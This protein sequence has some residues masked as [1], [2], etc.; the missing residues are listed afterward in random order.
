M[1][2]IINYNLISSSRLIFF[3]FPDDS[4]KFIRSDF[5]GGIGV[6]TALY[7]RVPSSKKT[8]P[9]IAQYFGQIPFSPE[10]PTGPG[11]PIGPA[12]PSSPGIP[13]TP[14]SPLGPEGP[15]GP[16]GPSKPGGPGGPGGPEFFI[17]F[18]YS[19]KKV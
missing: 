13:S 1:E 3:N 11:W 4:A 19:S 6:T 17:F 7:R 10:L 18:N 12:L 15:G 2:F 9:S 5:G 16:S 8:P 14:G